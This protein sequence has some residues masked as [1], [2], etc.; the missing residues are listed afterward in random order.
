MCVWYAGTLSAK[1][2]TMRSFRTTLIITLTL[3]TT[4]LGQKAYPERQAEVQ[5]VQSA[6]VASALNMTA[7]S[8]VISA[9]DRSL[10]VL[11][12][13]TFAEKAQIP[14]A[15]NL[16]VTAFALTKSGQKIVVGRSD[17]T[18]TSFSLPA[19]T[20]GVPV[21]PHKSSVVALDAQDEN[22][23]YT[24][25][26]DKSLT[27]SDILSGTVLGTLS[28]A[29]KEPTGILV[30]KDGRRFVVAFADGSVQMYTLAGLRPA[31]AFAGNTSR[32]T[33]TAFS[34]DGKVFAAGTF[35]GTVFTWN[36]DDGTLLHQQQAHSS[37]V[38]DIAFSS[39]M[40]WFVSVSS[41]STMRIA[42]GSTLA[43]AATPKATS[44]YW[45]QVDFG[46]ED[47][48]IAAMSTGSIETWII[49]TTPPD[50]DPP[51]IIVESPEQRGGIPLRLF[52]RQFELQAV[53]WD[54]LELASV[55]LNGKPI[56]VTPLR[57]TD[58]VR[59]PAGAVSGRFAMTIK[60]DSIGRNTFTLTA[61]DGLG[62]ATSKKILVDR[63]SS[64]EALEILAPEVKE[65][66][67]VVS[68]PIQFRAWFDVKSVSVSSNLIPIIRN[69]PIK[70]KLPGDVITEEVPLVVGYNQVQL[71]VNGMRGEQITR[72]IGLSRK[73]TATVV[74]A[75]SKPVQRAATGG[76]QR[77]AV[78][79]GVSDYGNPGIPSL[80][81]AD[82]DAEAFA[83]FLRSPQG[84]GYDNDHMRLLLNENATFSNI[85]DALMDFLG[86]AIDI[87]LVMIYFAGHGA[88][89]PGRPQNLY[90]LAHD[91][92]PNKLSTTAFPM[93]QMQDVLSRYI[94]SKRIAVFT[95]ACH[96]GG[97]SVDFATR[98]VGVTDQNLVNQ[99]LSDLSRSKEGTVVF[100]ASAAGE[101]SQEFP[102]F[103][104]GVFTYYLLEGL[105]G[106]A[107][108]NN[109]YTITIN[110]AM[111]YTE[112]NVKRKT[113][114]AQN[115]TRSQTSY[116]KDLTI[117]IIPH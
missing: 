59:V 66:L 34:P 37:S 14:T 81:Y 24:I 101:V 82:K 108:Y 21:S 45:T 86:N 17:G 94:S 28:L 80:T 96:S 49:K 11:D 23:A 15:A 79:V 88:P 1:G 13:K 87:D 89:D 77:W 2:K 29:P 106:K 64:S 58:T 92:D 78:V 62:L 115:P 46:A 84:G 30:H 36:A 52:A 20:P 99:Y 16:R 12:A 33:A 68:I 105:R 111:Q 41:D 67:D 75:P 85:R 35:D 76:P 53:M 98:G 40:T 47:R 104:H 22:L 48:L 83:N 38:A 26:M 110:E 55:T 61:T 109:D 116:D 4:A 39:S 112:E 25:G 56:A 42:H 103:G 114:G 44:G 31:H 63:L 51:V 57:S 100:T 18:V 90:L 69:K 10:R 117:S 5:P 27:I 107:D 70:D 3:S 71:E 43:E 54:N 97:I 60:L 65:D 93:W 8:Y 6:I 73:Y 9:A 74:Q 19:G 91:T 50:V 95:D 72:T 102:E 113:R 32:I 7:G